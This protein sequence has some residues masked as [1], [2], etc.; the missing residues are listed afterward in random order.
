MSI[1]Y[2]SLRLYPPLSIIVWGGVFSIGFPS[3]PVPANSYRPPSLSRLVCNVRTDHDI[4]SLNSVLF[5]PR[6]RCGDSSTMIAIRCRVYEFTTLGAGIWTVWCVL[7]SFRWM[8]LYNV[9]RTS[10]N[11]CCSIYDDLWRQH[12]HIIAHW[13]IYVGILCII[14]ACVN[15]TNIKNLSWN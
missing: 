10:H 11:V 9:F 3:S 4:R 5:D 12:K 14:C 1:W 15:N 2:T 8:Y 6:D 13:H 7:G